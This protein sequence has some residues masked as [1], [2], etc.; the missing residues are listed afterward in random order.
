ME[1]LDFWKTM[2]LIIGAAV[3]VISFGCG[4]DDCIKELFTPLALAIKIIIVATIILFYALHNAQKI[5]V[6][7]GIIYRID[8]QPSVKIRMATADVPVSTSGTVVADSLLKAPYSGKD[9][10]YYHAI[11]EEL[12]K[13][14]EHAKWVTMENRAEYVPFRIR[15]GKDEIGVDLNSIDDDISGYKIKDLNKVGLFRESFGTNIPVT[16]EYGVPLKQVP[17]QT[18]SEIDCVKTMDKVK[19]SIFTKNFFIFGSTKELRR[20]EYILP[21]GTGVFVYGMVQ[22]TGGEL[23]IGESPGEPLIISKRT[24]DE[25]VE[26]FFGGRVNRAIYWSCF[27]VSV[28]MVVFFAGLRFLMPL[29]LQLL[30]AAEFGIVVFLLARVY[31]RIVLLRQRT[32][33]SLGQIDIQLGRRANLIPGM[34]EAV[35]KYAEYERTVL[36]DIAK[37]RA[38]VL[39]PAN[40]SEGAA[41]YEKEAGHL[42]RLFAVM[43]K[44]PELRASDNFRKF[45]ET[46]ADSEERISYARSFYNRTVLKYNTLISTFPGMLYAPLF[47]FRKAQYFSL[48]K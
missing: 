10:V 24:K 23:V 28:A 13:S 43:E 26:D 4:D 39:G 16:V 41:V 2:A 27:L 3:L 29:P 9:C 48:E 40:A 47:G 8:R 1:R 7:E 42:K 44:Y 5:S 30:M 36:E 31:N 14:R 15:D 11:T 25:Y 38:M 12:D 45:V 6:Y 46:L 32:R 19:E 33:D 35:K 34:L 20:T 17:S 18:N 37:L 21:P 22:K